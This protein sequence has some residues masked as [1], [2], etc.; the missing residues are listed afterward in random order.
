MPPFGSRQK[1]T[2]EFVTWAPERRKHLRVP[3]DGWVE[4]R[5]GT[6]KG[7]WQVLDLSPGGLRALGP[8]YL[9]PRKP[10]LFCVHVD[11]YSF[12]AQADR[13]WIG[14]ESTA[15]QHGWRFRELSESA[16]AT[17][18][19]A[20][21]RTEEIVRIEAPAPPPLLPRWLQAWGLSLLLVCVGLVAAAW[22]LL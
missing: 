6:R 5:Q 12:W 8:Y 19:T 20:L 3:V 10:I 1:D 4:F 14:E 2:L 7:S 17:L 9:D 13:A 22:I 21:E 18:D 15:R 16:R 11:D